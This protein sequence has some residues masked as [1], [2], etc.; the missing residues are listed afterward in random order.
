MHVLEDGKG[1]ETL[2][3]GEELVLEEDAEAAADA[4][5][6]GFGEVAVEGSEALFD[7]GGF[8]LLC[9]GGWERRVMGRV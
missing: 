1:D 4:E 2:G 8:I 6:V 7:G 3:A 5:T 9:V